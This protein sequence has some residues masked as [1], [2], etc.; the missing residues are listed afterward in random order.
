MTMQP[1]HFSFWLHHHLNVVG[2]NY[3]LLRVENTI[4][5]I[6]NEFVKKVVLCEQVH[7]QDANI[8][9]IIRQ[10][11]RQKEF[12]NRCLSDYCQGLGIRF[13]LH[14]DDDEL[15][16][17]GKHVESFQTLLEQSFRRREIQYLRIQNYEAVLRFTP[18]HQE[19]F[20]QTSWFK[21]ANHEE[22]RSYK[23]G[24]SI[25][26]VGRGSL[27]NGCHTFTGTWLKLAEE[28]AII[29]HYDSITFDKWKSKFNHLKNMTKIPKSIFPFYQQSI[30]LFLRDTSEES[31]HKFWQNAVSQCT[32]PINITV[33]YRFLKS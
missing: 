16:L 30:E 14:I 18:Q 25:A 31:L 21:N 24:K 10:Q 7:V 33:N 32:N 20:F 9:S 22:C 19:Y 15:L 17:V 11:D 12:V 27:C 6:P 13:L 3:I 2:V 28:D 8:D 26:Y 23:N 1:E 4:L 5:Q 29:A